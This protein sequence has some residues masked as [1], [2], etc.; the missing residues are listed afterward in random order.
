[1]TDKTRGQRKQERERR[2]EK[3]KIKK[4]I[5]KGCGESQQGRGREREKKGEWGIERE[6]EKKKTRFASIPA[7]KKR[8]QPKTQHQRDCSNNHHL[9]QS[10]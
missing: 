9:Q 10:Q 8:K 3:N 1:M 5:K 6:G 2:K 4:K 7:D